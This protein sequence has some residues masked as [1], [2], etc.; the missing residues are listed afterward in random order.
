[1]LKSVMF[2][3]SAVVT[4]RAFDGKLATTILFFQ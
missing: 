1:L 3:T 2:F 4:V